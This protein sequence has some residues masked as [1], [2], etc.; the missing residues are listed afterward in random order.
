MS[1]SYKTLTVHRAGIDLPFNDWTPTHVSQ[2]FSWR[3]ESVSFRVMEPENSSDLVRLDQA[4]TY[5][6]APEARR[7]I[8]V[9]FVVEAAGI[10]VTSPFS[11]AWAVPLPPGQYALYFAIEPTPPAEEQA[12]ESWGYHLTFVQTGEE[13][14]AEILRADE[15]LMPPAQL[16]MEAQPAI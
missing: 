5:I 9:P 1:L 6:P 4:E 15:E 3:P 13:V 10:E 8:R 11:E 14:K 7:I 2:G 16:L 12:E